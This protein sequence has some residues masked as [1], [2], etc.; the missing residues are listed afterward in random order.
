MTVTAGGD[1]RDTVN[2]EFAVACVRTQKIAYVQG[3]SIVVAYADGSNPVVV[4]ATGYGPSWSSDGRRLLY[5]TL[6]CEYYGYYCAGG[7]HIV[8]TETGGVTA[9]MNGDGGWD[10][11]WSPD[12]TSIAFV[13]VSPDA[14]GR[15]AII[16]AGVDLPPVF[17]VA[18]G[19]LA[20]WAWPSSPSW[21]PDGQR[22]VFG[23]TVVGTT[24]SDICAVNRNGTG[25]QR[26]TQG[27]GN[28]DP[29]WS[30]DGS[31]I[32]FT[33]SRFGGQGEIALMNP[34]GTGFTR[35]VPGFSPA[36]TP[37]GQIL[38][39]STAGVHVVNQDGS[40]L[41]RLVAGSTYAPAWR[42]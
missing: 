41:T 30:P 9:V 17:P 20:N 24:A 32:A 33:T 4:A 7:L 42:P 36:W 34:D 2:T 19:L 3:G 37:S 23:C 10:P 28:F 12:G 5:S 35:V 38:F 22:I 15:V 31:R 21:S 6:E 25:F 18:A 1:K 16:T 39:A 14:Y 13:Y 8:D 11:A 40:G 27:E 26:L 29:A